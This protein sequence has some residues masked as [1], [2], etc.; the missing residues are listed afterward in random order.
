MALVDV[1]AGA[2]TMVD[3]DVVRS[4]RTLRLIDSGTVQLSTNSVASR[5]GET[6]ESSGSEVEVLSATESSVQEIQPKAPVEHIV[7]EGESLWRIARHYYRRGSLWPLI[8][9]ENRDV[10]GDP[11]FVRAGV[12]LRIPEADQ[13]DV[14]VRSDGQ[15][16]KPAS[17]A[18]EFRVSTSSAS[19]ENR[20]DGLR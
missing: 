14:S 15:D 10:I 5:R 20:S 16:G 1:T 18:S 3:F 2:V 9:R 4:K 6:A 11:E 8:Y 19:A 13:Q 7:Q 12:T 17:A